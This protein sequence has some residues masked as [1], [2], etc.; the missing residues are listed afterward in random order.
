MKRA[1]GIAAGRL[2]W[3]GALAGM[4]VVL[5]ATPAF[6]D[7]GSAR[8]TPLSDLV[9][10]VVVALAITLA[11]AAGSRAYRRGRF[12]LLSRVADRSGE[13]M[14]MAPWAALP[15]ILGAASL[16]TAAF[17]FYW[18]VS[19]HIDRGRDPGPF[20]NPAHWFI[21]VGLAGVA[22]AGVLAVV[23]GGTEPTSSS[24]RFTERWHPPVGGVLLAICG[25]IALAGFPLDDIWHRIFGQDVTLWGPTHIQMVGGASLAT[26][27]LWALTVEGRR[28]V[29]GSSPR[30]LGSRLIDLSCGGALL[31]GL[32]TLQGEFD[33]GVP[34]FRLLYQPVLIMLAAGIALVA[35]RLRSGRGGALGAAVFFVGLRAGLTVVIG[36]VLGRSTLHFPL[37][38][39][40]ALLVEAVALFVATDRQIEFG[41][42][43]GLA[44][45]TIGLAAEWLW[46]HVWMPLPWHADLFP[47]AAVL[48]L[49]AAVAGGVLGGLVGRAL[50]PRSAERAAVP[51][52][53]LAAWV[54][55]FVCVAVPLPTTTAA[56]VSAAIT[57][58]PVDAGP[59]RH[60][61]VSLRTTPANA[62][63]HAD[64]FTVTAWQGERKGRGGLVIAPLHQ[65]PDGTYAS[66]TPIPVF[67]TWKALVRLHRGDALSTLPLYLPA[68]PAIPAAA[69]D[70][71][72][73]MT[74][75]FL[76]DKKVLQREAIGGS[77]ALQ[78]AA[79]AVL[80]ILAA[81]WIASLAWGLRRLEG[82][83]RRPGS[84]MA[85]GPPPVPA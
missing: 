37:Y 56:N 85:S 20:A 31:L 45:G 62:A 70:A 19:W 16:V 7:G 78:R 54:V 74:R 53:A 49:A 81:C 32:S 24:V 2:A 12:T 80:A 26:L 30:R 11:V 59:G 23:L 34:Q 43:A 40:E 65:M 50:T 64:W 15:T 76:R 68:D 82:G 77:P 79:Y 44:I 6:A 47:L 52:I 14:E 9:P 39:V 21:I 10:S 48:G 8:G 67:G 55:A 58:R 66:R 5:S 13:V 3:A 36:P 27:A 18:D 17:G 61:L 1:I 84:W 41:A 4:T 46:S 38:L 83:R 51:R 22:L 75:S 63:A 25:L 28:V 35:A 60:V 33:Y 29:V 42:V 73:T 72:P 69:V 71:N 57:L